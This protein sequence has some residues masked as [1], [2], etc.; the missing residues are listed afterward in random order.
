V[1]IAVVGL[2]FMGSRWARAL[3]E[4]PLAE[5]HT[6]SDVRE[7]L[8]RETAERLGVSFVR[9]GLDAAD[10]PEVEAVVVCTPE[11]LHVEPALA[12]ISA[13]KAVLVEKPLAHT[14]EDAVRIRDRA[15][16]R[17]VPVLAGHILRF[18]ARYAAARRALEAGEL[19]TVQAVRHER[20]G[21]VRDQDVLGGRTTIP[22]YY[23]VHELDLARWY[24]GEV[25]RITAERSEGVLRAHG[26]PI[27]D[28]Y[29]AVLR[30]ATGAHGTAML[31]WSLPGTTPGY[32]LAG[33]TII[34][35]R[36]VL[37]ISQ[38][39]AGVV[40]VDEE[41]AR[42]PDAYYAPEVHGRLRGALAVEADHFVDC[43][44]GAAEPLCTAHD[45]A[46]A[47][48]LALAMESSAER[49]EPV[50]LAGYPSDPV[51]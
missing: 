48:R 31:G 16:E 18:E 14:V 32:G 43:A 45:G 26:Y 30:F 12:A 5:L 6:V 34:G 4:H 47:V 46:E 44:R 1:P 28:L 24:A 20:I 38:G 21:L 7:A 3:A 11:H 2:G 41:G 42:Y 8:G 33:V 13:G 49:G 19:G 17:G 23:G 40:V 37:R 39:D 9:D 50:E 29:S 51:R 22:L 15:A 27:E 10:D 36:G 25:E 35:E